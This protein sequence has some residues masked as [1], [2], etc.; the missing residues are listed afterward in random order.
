MTVS[1]LRR[2][3]PFTVI[4][5]GV[6]GALLVTASAAIGGLSIVNARRSTVALVSHA[7][8]EL[9]ELTVGHTRA[10]LAEAEH[11]AA[12]APGMVEQGL[13]DPRD[14]VQLGRYFTAVV[15]AHPQLA[16]ASWGGADDHFIGAWRNPS[17][18]I[19]LNHSWPE[20]EAIIMRERRLL[21]DGGW[22][23]MRSSEDYDYRPSPRPWWQQAATAKVLTWTEPYDFL[24]SGGVGITCAQPLLDGAGEVVGVFTIDFFLEELS[25]FLGRLEVTEHSLVG[26]V[27]QEGQPI[28][29]S[30]GLGSTDDPL[31]PALQRALEAYRTQAHPEL[32]LT[33]DHERWLARVSPFAV[34]DAT[35]L[36]ILVAPEADF[37][38][39]I[40]AQQRQALALGMLSLLL[41]LA[42]GVVTGRWIARPLVELTH[43][44]RRVRSGDLEVDFTAASSD[45]IGTLTLALAD[46]VQALKDRE[47]I[48]GVLGRYANP[49][50][51]E[52]CLADPDALALGGKL[53][54]VTVL[55]SD[56][57]G[58]TKLTER[59]GPEEMINLLNDYLGR[60]ATVI[61]AHGG[62]IN[63]FIGDA[64]L[65]LFGAPFERPD[66]PE[67]AVRCAHAMQQALAELNRDYEACGLPALGM[68]IGVHCGPVVAGNIGSAEHA[69]YGVVGTTINATARIEA[70]T[71]GTQTLISG[72]LYARTRNLAEVGPR[73]SEELKGLPEPME[74]YELLGV[75][76]A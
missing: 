74:I 29:A 30:H 16:W 36:V 56:L 71:V 11:L 55:M 44:A 50:L 62:T 32:T 31:A 20:G 4:L 18:E 57:R 14:D 25:A 34:G 26:V 47:F 60:M 24:Y 61:Q 73:R 23:P 53:Q 27:T 33:V 15:Q 70:L 43:K 68:G 54:Q 76:E 19:L 8:A 10:F 3:P 65:V 39:P 66:D 72:E 52:R 42:A 35:W 46:M 2:R 37:M 28:A 40:R 22:A 58:F 64:I 7:M 5:V 49:E 63:E 12:V 38:A 51:A 6:L 48:Q 41:S 67:R 1:Q 45:E 13:L 75:D 59:L 17:G 69:K 9:A 21:D